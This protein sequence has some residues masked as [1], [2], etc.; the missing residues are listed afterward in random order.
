MMIVWTVFSIYIYSI[1]FSCDF[2]SGFLW[3]LT[4]GGWLAGRFREVG[5]IH[6][7]LLY[8]GIFA[9]PADKKNQE[10]AQGVA[11][12]TRCHGMHGEYPL[13]N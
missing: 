3:E 10:M 6:R 9:Y 12:I 13:V 4:L 8:G 1:V 2:L 11:V 7:T 5:D